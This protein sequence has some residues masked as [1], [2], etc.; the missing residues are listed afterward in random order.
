[1]SEHSDLV[2]CS[3]PYPVAETVRRLVVAAQTHGVT[4]FATVDHAAGA[5][6]VGLDMP[7]TQVMFVGNPAVGTPAML[8]APDLAL[9]LP[10]RILVREAI[11]GT[12][13][14]TVVFHDPNEIARTH[15]LS[16]ARADGLRGV[17]ALVDDALED[18]NPH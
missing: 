6:S 7:E 13:G 14:S 2:E 16:T 18:G 5:R 10:T 8:E 11:P 1:M 9:D 15:S 17:V 12:S 3:S 4:V